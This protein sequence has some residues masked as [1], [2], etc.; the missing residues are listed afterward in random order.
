MDG[1]REGQMMVGLGVFSRWSSSEGSMPKALPPSCTLPDIPSCFADAPKGVEILLSSSGR[2]ILPGDLV[3]LTCRV[4]SSYPAVSSVQW[5]KDGVSLGVEGRVLRLSSATWNDSGVYTCQ[6]T[7]NV[8][9]LVSPPLSL[10][11]FSE[12]WMRLRGPVSGRH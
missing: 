9:S 10:H 5:A 12:S 2:N 7:N 1:G 8:G 6:A 3:T 4:N 11:V